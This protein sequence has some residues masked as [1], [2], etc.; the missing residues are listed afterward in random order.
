MR[1]IKKNTATLIFWG[2][3]PETRQF[4]GHVTRNT[5]FFG[6]CYQKHIN[7][8]GMLPETQQFLCCVFIFHLIIVCHTHYCYYRKNWLNTYW[9]TP[10]IPQVQYWSAFW[11]RE[12]GGFAIVW[13]ADQKC[14]LCSK[15]SITCLDGT[16]QW[17][18]TLWPGDTFLVRY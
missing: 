13:L 8:W 14:L 6:A 10:T 7:F 18:D 12:N 15:Y 3:L 2:M 16:L 5:T 1:N 4:L 9:L 17:E 11:Q